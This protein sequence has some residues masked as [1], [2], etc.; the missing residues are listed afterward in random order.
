MSRLFE[1][2][3]KSEGD[4]VSFDFSETAEL[5]PAALASLV[6]PEVT[7]LADMLKAAEPGPETVVDF[8]QFQSLRIAVNQESRV[9]TVT[10]KE[11]LGAE[12]FRFLGVRLRQLQ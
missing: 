4:S 8:G 6:E 11:S 12:K 10:D 2:L 5:T 7:P 9:I 3:Q 1:A